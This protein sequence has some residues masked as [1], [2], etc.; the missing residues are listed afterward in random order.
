MYLSY[1]LRLFLRTSVILENDDPR[2][3]CVTLRV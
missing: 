3:R 2:T 1:L